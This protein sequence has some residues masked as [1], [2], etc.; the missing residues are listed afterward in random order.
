M[1]SATCVQ[2]SSR[3]HSSA[4]GGTERWYVTPIG[5]HDNRK[6]SYE[7]SV[8]KSFRLSYGLIQHQPLSPIFALSKVEVQS[9]TMLLQIVRPLTL[10]PKD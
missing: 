3:H 2:R 10:S 1:S 7:E 4:A 5:S 9:P 8:S 6:T